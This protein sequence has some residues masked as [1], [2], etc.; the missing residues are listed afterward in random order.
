MKGFSFFLRGAQKLWVPRESREREGSC[1][2]ERRKASREP[3][4]QLESVKGR[5]WLCAEREG[6]RNR[7]KEKGDVTKI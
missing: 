5:Q 1:V 2:W 4:R 7:E 6:S 3:E